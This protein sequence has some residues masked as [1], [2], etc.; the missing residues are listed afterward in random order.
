[1][2]VVVGKLTHENFRRGDF[3]NQ[4]A[5]G[6]GSILAATGRELGVSQKGLI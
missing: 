5:K 3:W 2:F 1:M 4:P 6:F